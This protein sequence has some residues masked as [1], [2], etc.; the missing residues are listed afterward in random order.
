ME[1]DWL[2]YHE[3]VHTKKPSSGFVEFVT[4]SEPNKI[5]MMDLSISPLEKNIYWDRAS[6]QC[7]SV[8]RYIPEVKFLEA[9]INAINIQLENLNSNIKYLQE[10]KSET[11]NRINELT[12]KD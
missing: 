12:K 11:E 3:N 9:K 6:R 10:I 1:N 2:I 7:V 8:F 4:I 5:Q